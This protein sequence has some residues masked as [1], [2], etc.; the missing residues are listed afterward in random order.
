LFIPV[1]WLDKLQDTIS[2]RFFS[3]DTA[4]DERAYSEDFLRW[5]KILSIPRSRWDEPLM[6]K[7]LPLLARAEQL[8]IDLSTALDFFK[9]GVSFGREELLMSCICAMLEDKITGKNEFG[10]YIRG[11]MA[12]C[13]F[14]VKE[15]KR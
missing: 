8:Q 7:G 6:R 12:A 9:D 2:E 5:A 4:T 15:S 13:G 3:M 10:E 14:E 1:T 11:K